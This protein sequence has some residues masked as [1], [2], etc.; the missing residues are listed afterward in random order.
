MNKMGVVFT[1]DKLPQTARYNLL[2]YLSPKEVIRLCNI[3]K[4]TRKLF[5]EDYD[6]W[7]ERINKECL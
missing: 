1:F 4:N 3:N 6:V 7:I 2:T 5:K